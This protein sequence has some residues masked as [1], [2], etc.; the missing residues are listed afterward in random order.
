MKK[1]IIILVVFSF[2]L[3][4]G[5]DV[6]RADII[7]PAW[8]GVKIGKLIQPSWNPGDPVADGYC[9][10]DEGNDCICHFTIIMATHNLSK[11][12]A[13]PRPN[14]GETLL[15]AT[16]TIN[17]NSL[18]IAF[19]DPTNYKSPVVNQKKPINLMRDT[20]KQFGYKSIQIL[21]GKYTLVGNKID[22]K[23]KLGKRVTSTN[24]KG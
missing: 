13:R 19:K 15:D 20:C 3:S 18:T 6:S 8:V 11:P 4:F 24:S 17:N 14:K 7:D 9:D 12:L 1:H 2:L 21:P 22:F 23:V 10:C 5:I 16:V